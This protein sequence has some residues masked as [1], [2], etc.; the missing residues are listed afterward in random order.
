MLNQE[1]I[2]DAADQK[3]DLRMDNNTAIKVLTSLAHGINPTTGE[4]L[5]NE[6]VLNG[7]DATRALFFAVECMRDGMQRLI[8]WDTKPSDEP[9]RNLSARPAAHVGKKRNLDGVWQYRPIYGKTDDTEE[10]LEH[11]LA[12]GLEHGLVQ[13]LNESMDE[14]IQTIV[15][16]E[17]S[18]SDKTDIKNK[19]QPLEKT[20]KQVEMQPL[21]QEQQMLYEKMKSWRNHLAIS[22]GYAP[23]MILSND[24]LARV[25]AEK[26]DCIE[27]LAKIKGFGAIKMQ[28]YAI[29]VLALVRGRSAEEVLADMPDMR[30]L[31]LVMPDTHVEIML[32]PEGAHESSLSLC[33][34]YQ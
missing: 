1:E 25:A 7:V 9:K 28:K 8:L 33:P 31:Q 14:A 3:E 22:N 30:P 32:I 11:G 27:A 15:K 5:P 4:F 20:V 24:S 2:M 17:I 19:V 23:Y 34:E 26:P 10:G 13:D 18:E 12:H 16:S 21:D 6:S 29:A